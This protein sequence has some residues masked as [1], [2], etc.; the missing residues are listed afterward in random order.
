MRKVLILNHSRPVYPSPAALITSADAKGN[1]NILTLGEVFNVSVHTPV[2]LGLA[3]RKA[4]YSHELI[5]RSREF[6]INLP[7]IKILEA[8]D[9]CGSI[10]GR[11]GINKFEQ[12]H[13]TPL[14]ADHVKAPLIEECPVNLECKVLSITAVGDHDLF[15]GEMVAM[16]VDEDKVTPSQE[17]RTE[18]LDMVV[19]VEWEYWNVGKKIERMGFTS[20]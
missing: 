9:T 1:P 8:V 13:L 18:L 17:I 4:T 11:N 7:T 3:I 20:F 14:P 6:V 15:L 5:S 12:F 16:H 10:S 2:I 19:F